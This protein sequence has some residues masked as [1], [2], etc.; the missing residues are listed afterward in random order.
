MYFKPSDISAFL[1]FLCHKI[2]AYCPKD[3]VYRLSVQ[4]IFIIHLWKYILRF[5]VIFGRMNL[6]SLY[7]FFCFFSTVCDF[8]LKGFV[9]TMIYL[10]ILCICF[11]I[12]A[13]P[14]FDDKLFLEYNTFVFLCLFIQRF[15]SLYNSGHINLVFCQ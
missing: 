2:S 12:S 10:Q 4:L 14:S 8:W 13:L 15:D 11:R 1:C 3:I 6:Y 7:L 5:C 9:L